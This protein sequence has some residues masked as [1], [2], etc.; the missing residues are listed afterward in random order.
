MA[1]HIPDEII[2]EILYPAL[3]V[4][5]EAFS[6]ISARTPS[7]VASSESSSAYLLVSKS[8]LRVG[9]PLVYN[10]VI[11]RSKAQAQALA[12]TLRSNPDLGRF[13][14]KLRVEGGYAI[15]ML[16][17]LQTAKNLTDLYLSL[18][19]EKSDNACGMCRGLPLID[20]VRV[21]L[22]CGQMYYSTKSVAKLVDALA[23]SIPKWKNL[24]VFEVPHYD[25]EMGSTH[26]DT[27]SEALEASPTLRTLVIS[28]PRRELFRG[29]Y[30]PEYILTIAANPSLKCIQPRIQSRKPLRP[31]FIE[32]VQKDA[33]LKALIDLQP[34][35]IAPFVY[36]PQLAAD[37]GL[38]DV[39]WG[40]VLSFALHG[41]DPQS[42]PGNLDFDDDFSSYDSDSD[43][44]DYNRPSRYVRPLLVCK[45]F[46]RLGIP[47]L[48]ENP[49]LVSSS[50]LRKFTLRLLEQPS[51]RV[52]VRRLLFYKPYFDISSRESFLEDILPLTPNLVVLDAP[53]FCMS[54]KT[55]AALGALTGKNL[56][57]FN[58][59]INKSKKMDPVVLTQFS[60]MR[61]L[62]WDSTIALKTCSNSM[63]DDAFN[64]LVDLNFRQADSSFFTVLSQME[65]PSLRNVS[66]A[67]NG[68]VTGGDVFFQKHG[69]KLQE[70]TVSIAQLDVGLDVFGI[71]PSIKV[72]GICSDMTTGPSQRTSFALRDP[73][74]SLERIVFKPSFY[75][76]FDKD[77]QQKLEDLL[78]GLD[79]IMFPALREIQHT[80]FAWP[81]AEP[82]IS[83]S[84]WVTWAETLRERDIHLVDANGVQWRRRL[85]FRKSTK[86]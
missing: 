81:L 42:N 26:T 47:C 63:P 71:C 61:F 46:L 45:L 15:S 55:F 22:H 48:Y 54:V 74:A 17:I 84:C 43:D 14:K 51:L 29:G 44:F 28:D 39:I 85:Q 30:V 65:L 40:R 12:V 41:A 78:L 53:G 4:P 79:R 59:V 83:Q 18:D 23:E 34:F 32:T 38:R 2:H 75:S 56:R 33:R 3:R 50:A 57:I 1:S 13:I 24:I 52:H 27:I 69:K 70:L 80:H 6:A 20:P 8:W 25:Y 10:V 72:L 58:G 5:D 19:I 36:P 11:I 9:T 60:Q 86:K 31:E 66:F 82:E 21:I 76:G 62:T 16:K 37:P 64:N 73:Y 68:V 67:Y 77:M 49:V 7:T 35:D